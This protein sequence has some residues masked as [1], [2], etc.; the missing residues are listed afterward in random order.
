MKNM[1]SDIQTRKCGTYKM[2][3]NKKDNRVKITPVG[4]I[5][6]RPGEKVKDDIYKRIQLKQN[7]SITLYTCNIIDNFL[8]ATKKIPMYYASIIYELPL[9]KTILLNLYFNFTIGESITTQNELINNPLSGSYNY[10][11]WISGKCNILEN[12]ITQFPGFKNV[13]NKMETILT[14][15]EMDALIED[16]IRTD[17]NKYKEKFEKEYGHLS[18]IVKK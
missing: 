4:F 3:G 18:N 6:L 15:G 2:V 5:E 9:R 11:I 16:L 14:N 8:M 1:K 12:N 7:V 13:M 17:N 10:E